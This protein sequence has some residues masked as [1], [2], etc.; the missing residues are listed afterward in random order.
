MKNDVIAFPT[1]SNTSGALTQFDLYN[2]NTSAWSILRPNQN[3]A[4]SVNASLI[5]V[6]NT[7]YLAGGF[8][9]SGGCNGIFYDRV[10]TLNW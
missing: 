6:N 9:T 4:G 1:G 8:Q 2:V 3:I 7:V 10:Y 5:N